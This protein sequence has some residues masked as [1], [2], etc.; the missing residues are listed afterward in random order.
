MDRRSTGS[1]PNIQIS[2]GKWL[3][4]PLIVR[5]VGSESWLLS[6]IASWTDA[7]TLCPAERAQNAEKGRSHDCPL[8]E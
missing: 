8:Y 3:L 7:I 5:M 1:I 4:D 2:T 6:R